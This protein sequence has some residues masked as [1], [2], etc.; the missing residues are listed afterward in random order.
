MNQLIEFSELSDTTIFMTII[1]ELDFNSYRIIASNFDVSMN[2]FKD[3]EF[4]NN[5]CTENMF[6][7]KKLG[8]SN[9]RGS[10]IIESSSKISGSRFSI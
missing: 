8:L 6:E 2:F 1:H 10:K 9:S 3:I 5:L 4:I 7:R